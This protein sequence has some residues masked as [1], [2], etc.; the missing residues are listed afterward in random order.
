MDTE[1][2]TYLC[3]TLKNIFMVNLAGVF[4]CDDTILE[5]LYLANLEP[6]SS[7]HTGSSEVPYHYTAKLGMWT[8]R[9]AWNYWVAYVDNQQDGLKL[10][11]AFRLYNRQHPTLKSEILGKYIR[12]DGDCC[13]VSPDTCAMP[14]MNAELE[15]C[16][17]SLGYKKERIGDMGSFFKLSKGDI[18]SLCNDG[19]LEVERYIKLYHIDTQV[20]LNEFVKF[21][22]ELYNKN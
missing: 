3:L 5:E 2:F 22:K 1:T 4:L 12:C 17:L 8:F 15:N 6:V 9:R 21:I 7:I 18:T 11:D 19:K 13:G 14:V 10:H 16:L 20:G